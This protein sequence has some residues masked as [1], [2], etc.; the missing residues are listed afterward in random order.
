M[1]RRILTVLFL[2]SLICTAGVALWLV[3]LREEVPANLGSDMQYILLAPDMEERYWV[4]VASGAKAADRDLGTDTLLVHYRDQINLPEYIRDAGLSGA[5]GIIV[6][7]DYRCG[8][9]VAD[10]VESGIP[11]LFYDSDFPEKG[12]TSYVGNNNYALGY[13]A[14]ELLEE[15]MGPEGTYLLV[16]R[17]KNAPSQSERLRGIED[18]LSGFPALT[19]AQ[20]IEDMGEMMTLRLRL[21]EAMESDAPIRGILTLGGISADILGNL[22]EQF[23]VDPEE[24]SVIVTDLTEAAASY[25]QTGFYDAVI[26]LDPRQIGYRSVEA[27]WQHDTQGIPLASEV[28]LDTVIVTRENLSE[29]LKEKENYALEWNSY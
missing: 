10:V 2:A 18:A 29:Y 22:L 11:V 21:Q 8:D 27:L 9:A 25:I 3:S 15:L 7:G 24:V 20:V 17:S 12:R 26:A 6:K 19:C 16:V 1:R 5:K 13:Q 14:G 28:T 23:S 4:E